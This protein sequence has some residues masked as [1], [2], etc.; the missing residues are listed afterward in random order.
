[1]FNTVPCNLN[2]LFG[3]P[4]GLALGLPFGDKA[5][6]FENGFKIHCHCATHVYY[7]L[8]RERVVPGYYGQVR[9]QSFAN[10]V[11]LR[12]HLSDDAYALFGAERAQI[13][14]PQAFPGR[15][16]P[17]VDE[18]HGE[19]GPCYS[20]NPGMGFFNRVS[21][22]AFKMPDYLPRVTASDERHGYLGHGGVVEGRVQRGIAVDLVEIVHRQAF[23]GA[24]V[25]QK[26]HFPKD[27][28]DVFPY[29]R[30][31]R[32]FDYNA[33]DTE[34]LGGKLVLVVELQY[35]P[36][37]L[38]LLFNGLDKGRMP[39]SARQYVVAVVVV[40]FH[41]SHFTTNDGACPEGAG[42]KR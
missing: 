18:L 15:Q 17:A 2:R 6:I 20:I 14:E 35:V 24:L 39:S 42:A 22:F 27:G 23:A 3:F 30:A 21:A 11:L 34:G 29:D 33:V 32:L 37:L 31:L 13:P 19:N 5:G 16:L 28:G 12:G 41:V 38:K 4:F 9:P 8:Y 36:V 7:L 26:V 25:L 10:L 1:M 40:F